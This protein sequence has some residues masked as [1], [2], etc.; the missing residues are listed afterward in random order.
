[1]NLIDPCNKEMPSYYSLVGAKQ[2]CQLSQNFISD[3]PSVFFVFFS[4]KVAVKKVP[5]KAIGFC[6]S[7]QTETKK[8]SRPGNFP[9]I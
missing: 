5:V 7:S 1:M 8:K 4:G 3:F 2:C 9:S 6:F